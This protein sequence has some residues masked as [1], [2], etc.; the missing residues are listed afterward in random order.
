MEIEEGIARKRP[1]RSY[2]QRVPRRLSEIVEHFF[3]GLGLKIA[4]RP[5]KWLIGSTVI[6]LVSLSGLY[7]F[8]QEK[9]PMKLWVPQDSDFVHDT[10]WMID[11]FGQ[12]LRLE[13]M[14]LTADNVLEPGVLVTLNEITKEVISIQTSDHIAWTDVCF[15]VPVISGIVSRQKRSNGQDDFFDIEPELQI[16]STT[17]EAAVHADAKLYCNIVNNLPKACLINSIVDLWEYNSNVI[18]QKSKEEIIDDINKAKVSPT[19]GHPINFIDLL[20]GITKDEKGR[21]ISAKAVKTQWAVHINFSQVDMDN[22]GNDVG[23]ADWVRL[24]MTY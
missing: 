2:L 1:F 3:Y 21:I 18:I 19:L 20:G 13:N 16:N 17:F 12:G 24:R 15:K 22:F 10:E 6:V 8:R 9:N 4:Q 7:S 5:L 14:I 11:Q 23:T